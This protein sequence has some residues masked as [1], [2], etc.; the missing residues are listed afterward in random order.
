MADEKFL[1]L[2]DRLYRKSQAGKIEWKP[3]EHSAFPGDFYMELGDH[4]VTI[5]L[6][7]DPEYPED[8]DLFLRLMT[9]KGVVLQDLSVL[10]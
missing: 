8:P 6:K 10:D 7:L 4:Y 3:V 5:E 9:K 2:L 1:A